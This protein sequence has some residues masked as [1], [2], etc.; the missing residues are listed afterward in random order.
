MDDEENMIVTEVGKFVSV[1]SSSESA[2]G[3]EDTQ[4]KKKKR[5]KKEVKL[6]DSGT[7]KP[8]IS[9]HTD[10]EDE[11]D[12]RSVDLPVEAVNQLLAETKNSAT[13]WIRVKKALMINTLETQAEPEPKVVALIEELMALKREEVAIRRD[14]ESDG[15]RVLVSVAQGAVEV[16][17]KRRSQLLEAVIKYPR[18]WSSL[19]SEKEVQQGLVANTRPLIELEMETR[20]EALLRPLVLRERLGD[21]PHC[22]A[23]LGPGRKAALGILRMRMDAAVQA[24]PR[25]TATAAQMEPGLPVN[26]WTQYVYDLDA[27]QDAVQSSGSDLP[28]DYK[29]TQEKYLERALEYNTTFNLYTND[30]PLLVKREEDTMVPPTAFFEPMDALTDVRHVGGQVVAAIAWHP[31]HS[32]EV[33]VLY[34]PSTRALLQDRAG[35]PPPTDAFRRNTILLWSLRDPLK[36][37]SV[38]SSPREVLA[39]GWCPVDAN[40]LVGVCVSGQVVIWDLTGTWKRGTAKPELSQRRQRARKALQCILQWPDERSLH[41]VNVAPVALSA[42]AFSHQGAATDLQW[43]TPHHRLNCD[44]H[45]EQVPCHTIIP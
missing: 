39:V 4:K 21:S 37:R 41:A 44:G 26:A 7:P 18:P 10:L 9:P 14:A 36:P 45:Y 35:P 28:P 23:Q 17:S 34:A 29:F 2:E 1:P 31:M 11:P 19:G 42:P 13:G 20:A 24:V 38:L 12:I 6:Q 40:I 43:L 15:G 32:G 22:Y 3:S 8:I 5:K 33:A 27:V 16:E 30:Y 25:V